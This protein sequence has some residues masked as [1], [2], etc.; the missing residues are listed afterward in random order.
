MLREPADKGYVTCDTAERT[1]VM[2]LLAG[3]L[4]GTKSRGVYIQAETRLFVRRL[5]TVLPDAAM[6]TRS[7]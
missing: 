6:R 1:R 5:E 7:S 4:V 3:H 2:R